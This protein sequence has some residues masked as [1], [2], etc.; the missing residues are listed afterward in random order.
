MSSTL[1]LSRTLDAQAQ[2]WATAGLW[3]FAAVA[4]LSIAAQNILFVGLGAWCWQLWRARRRPSVPAWA[5]AYLAFALWALLASSQGMNAPHSLV[6]WRKWL[7]AVAALYAGDQLGR[8]ER[9]HAVLGALLL[10][11]A[12][13]CLGASLLALVHPVKAWAAGW[14]WPTLAGRWIWDADWRAR[15]GTGGY[16]VLGTCA[17]MVLVL[18]T[19]LAF[20]APRWRRPLVLAC[21]ASVA[22]ALLLTMTRGAWLAAGLGVGLILLLRKPWWLLSLGLLLG[23]YAVIAPQSIFV[24]RLRSVADTG[25]DSNRERIFMAQAG[26]AIVREHP[27]LGVG[28]SMESFD[29]PRP[30]GSVERVPGAF[31]SHRSAEAVDWYQRFAGGDREQGHLHSDWIQVAAM[32]G[33]PALGFLL[34]ALLLAALQALSLFRRAKDA[35]AA[36]LALGVLCVLLV[37]CFNGT[38][39][40]NFGSFQSSFLFWFLLGLLPAAAALEAGA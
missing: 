26:L 28:D 13:W 15:S 21:M 9:L 27:W 16:Q 19:S 30:D 34:L 18:Y 2:R 29:R 20:S 33:L 3:L 17:A 25:Y 32:D 24:E 8:R 22:L 36:G 31:L 12:L 5:W 11:T 1:S 14:D 35:E 4:C 39:E 23:A 38:F 40:Y 37:W 10:F 6:T 7:L